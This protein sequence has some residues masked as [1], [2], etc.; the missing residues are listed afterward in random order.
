MIL[1]SYPPLGVAYNKAAFKAWPNAIPGISDL[2]QLV[3]RK[4]ITASDYVTHVMEN[5]FDEHYAKGFLAASETMLQAAEYVTLWRRG[6][7]SDGD[8]Y[9]R[10]SVLAYTDEGIDLL[11]KVSEF[12]PSVGDLINFAVREVY[13][14]TI[15]EKYG[16]FEDLPR[17]YINESHKVG[18]S[19]DTAKLYWAAHWQLPSITQ[20]NE[21]LHRGVISEDE[22]EQLLRALDVMPYWR[23]RLRDISYNTLTRVDVRRMYSVGTLDKIGVYKS[24]R[25]FG[26]NDT[27]AKL[28]TDFTVKYES[29]DS[30][31]LNR[32]S[33]EKAYKLGIIDDGKL[34]EY[35]NQLYDSEQIARF[36]Y[37]IARTEKQND[38][39][40]AKKKSMLDRYQKGDVSIPQAQKELTQ[41]GYPAEYVSNTVTEMQNSKGVKVKLPS[42]QDLENW[43]KKGV[44]EEDYYTDTMLDIGY[45]EKDIEYYL[46]EIALER[47][48][49]DRKFLSR[50]V[51]VRWYKKGIISQDTFTE[52]LSKMGVF[53]EDIDKL[54]E[55]VQTELGEK[56]ETTA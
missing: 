34:L 1:S 44:I 21:M 15:A 13:T 45:R 54:I 56:E 32:S 29:G 2:L 41:A 26:Y 6:E 17:D 53:Q 52:N 25:E 18:L 10:L 40:A 16:Q 20:A 27:N 28:M 51:Y 8:L 31:E 3:R 30:L 5:G 50:Q 35:L 36:Y 48:T 4:E 7:L 43:L 22:H 9:E 19:E 23:P 11:K 55:E 38:E 33:L 14:P 47:D 37:N 42:R 39:L 49:S 12:Y 46:T 24:Y